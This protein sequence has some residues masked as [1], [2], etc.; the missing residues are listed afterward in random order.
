MKLI[1]LH[2]RLNN[3]EGSEQT[4]PRK[5]HQTEFLKGTDAMLNQGVE[6]NRDS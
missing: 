2:L 1:L 6:F 3:S 5:A 4:D